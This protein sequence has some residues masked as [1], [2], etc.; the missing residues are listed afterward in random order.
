MSLRRLLAAFGVAFATV[1][2]LASLAL[3]LLTTFLHRTN[4][5]L[6]D[7]ITR[8]ETT[9][10]AQMRLLEFN[11]VASHRLLQGGPSPEEID[12]ANREVEQLLTEYEALVDL[13]EGKRAVAETRQAVADYFEAWRNMPEENGR[14][15][16]TGDVAARIQ[17]AVKALDVLVERAVQRAGEARAQAHRWNRIAN[18]LAALLGLGEFALLFAYA[19]AIQR[20]VFRP[21]YRL[22]RTIDQFGEGDRSVRIPLE[23]I[24]ELDAVGLAFN[25]AANLLERQLRSVAAVAHDLRNPLAA[26]STAVAAMGSKLDDPEQRRRT[27]ELARR[28]VERLDRMITD[29]LDTARIEAGTLALRVEEADLQVIARATLDLLAPAA[30]RHEL[31]L[32]CPE[33]VPLRCDP[34]RIEQSLNNLVGNAIKYSP[35]GG[36]VAISVAVVDGWIRLEVRDYGLGI[37]PEDLDRIFEPFRRAPSTAQTIPG[38]G[39]GL[40]VTRRIIEMHGGR[41]E[42][43]SVLGQGSVFRCWLPANGPSR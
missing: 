3:F 4:E 18:V 19:L 42:V 22:R 23:H 28:Q 6:G 32:D 17:G 14:A 41:I 20:R 11:A 10:V 21:L 7:A 25:Q 30:P 38:V 16:F 5:R 36:R 34:G 39:L 33:H 27:S 12:S 35:N 24:D 37:A 15:Q 8:L 9:A 26:L 29:L 40:S 13:P 43:E 31:V 1:A 2:V